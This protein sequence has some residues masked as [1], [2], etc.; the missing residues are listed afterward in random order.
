MSR[1]LW[2]LAGAAAAALAIVVVAIA[3][4]QGGGSRPTPA[5]ATAGL[6]DAIPQHGAVLGHP[7]APVTLE[8]FADLQCP[9]CREYAVGALPEL[10]RR[11][12]RSGQLRLVFRPVA[13]LGPDSVRAAQ[14]ASAAGTQHR[15]W[16]FLDR[17]YSRQ[18]SENS[19]Y[20]TEAFLRSVASEV[21]GL[22][23]PRAL[24]ESGAE[25]SLT[26]LAQAQSR[27]RAFGIDSTPSFLIGRSG[28]AMH[29]LSVTSLGPEAFRA[30]I[31][32]ELAR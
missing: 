26:P 27:A 24:A 31:E 3:L 16:Q 11:Y 1:R 4:G 2:M 20:V 15:M 5:K 9:Y 12:V 14:M 17:F 25:A 21:S 13:I 18:Q 23:T 6:F 29:R 22:D 7:R 19:G 28:G 10:V 8:E 30:P 32:R